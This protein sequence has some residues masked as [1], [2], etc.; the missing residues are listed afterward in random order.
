MSRYKL[1]N[2]TVTPK[3]MAILDFAI[4]CWASP[5]IDLSYLFVL[6]MTPQ[7]RKETVKY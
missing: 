5:A 4:G 7:M 3:E 6:S 1:E 2:E